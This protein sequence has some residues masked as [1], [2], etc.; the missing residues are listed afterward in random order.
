MTNTLDPG[1][2]RCSD[3]TEC[4]QNSYCACW[5]IPFASAHRFAVVRVV[6]STGA[7][8]GRPRSNRP[9]PA[10]DP[11]YDPGHPDTPWGQTKGPR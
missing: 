8:T 5:R 3:P 2:G 9:D 4:R 10:P 6:A 11:S 7:D 1:C